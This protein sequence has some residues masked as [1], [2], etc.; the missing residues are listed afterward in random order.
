MDFQSLRIFVN[1]VEAGSFTEG[2]RILFMAQS[3]ASTSIRNLEREL[4]CPLLIRKKGGTKPTEEGKALYDYAR[5][6]LDLSEKAHGIGMDRTRFSGMLRIAS[7]ESSAVVRLASLFPAFTANYPDIRILLKT[8][9]SAVQMG[10]L[11]NGDVDFAMPGEKP[12]DASVE[13]VPLFEETLGIVSM[14]CK[15][16]DMRSRCDERFLVLPGG[17]SFRIRLESYI[18][19]KKILDAVFHEI[20]GIHTLYSCV[21]AGMGSTVLPQSFLEYH[22]AFEK[23]IEFVPL[24]R[25]ESR[26]IIHGAWRKDATDSGVLQAW[27]GFLTEN[28]YQMK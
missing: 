7:M 17:C 9:D 23:G 19:K 3:N 20:P 10:W 22:G 11:K 25:K 5:K 14:P 26:L 28:V 21:M 27:R 4:G 15:P 18:R 2:A 1:V 8:G 13:S 6:I 16:K 24:Q 12:G